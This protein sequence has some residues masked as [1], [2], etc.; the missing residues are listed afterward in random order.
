M[1][2]CS[3]RSSL[4]PIKR[5]RYRGVTI[6]MTLNQNDEK[7]ILIV[8]DDPDFLELMVLRF[9]AQG[10][11]AKSAK[12]G[13]EGLTLSQEEHFDVILSDIEM[14]NLN[15]IEF[16]SQVRASENNASAV[17]ILMSGAF[18]EKQVE[19]LV[20]YELGGFIEKPFG[21]DSLMEMIENSFK[22]KKK[23]E[24]QLKAASG[25]EFSTFSED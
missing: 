4:N 17:M 6:D 9:E 12:D 21:D 13:E 7:R 18:T 19:E 23:N 22:K 5:K 3:L 8:E 1:L 10:W 24:E 16:L 25:E 20:Q 2:K 15:G 14:P 11:Q